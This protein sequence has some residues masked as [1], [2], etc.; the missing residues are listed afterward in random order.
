MQKGFPK[1]GRFPFTEGTKESSS[2]ESLLSAILGNKKKASQKDSPHKR[3]RCPD[4]S[5]G[6]LYYT[7]GIHLGIDPIEAHFRIN[8]V[9]VNHS[10]SFPKGVIPV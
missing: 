2:P 6:V 1:T 9:I 7:L 5:K 3:A 8:R 4:W 10:G